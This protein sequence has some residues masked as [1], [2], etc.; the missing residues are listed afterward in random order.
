VLTLAGTRPSPNCAASFPLGSAWLNQFRPYLD[1]YPVPEAASAKNI[2]MPEVAALSIKHA[3]VDIPGI[4]Q[5]PVN[6]DESRHHC[7]NAP[8][9]PGN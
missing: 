2:T 9:Y 5:I 1:S 8:M 4:V 6:F 3:C 7:L